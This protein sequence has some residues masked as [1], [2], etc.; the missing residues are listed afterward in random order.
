M[1]IC[2]IPETVR[3][4]KQSDYD[5]PIAVFISNQKDEFN[6]VPANTVYT[7]RLISERDKNFIGIFHCRMSKKEIITFLREGSDI[8]FK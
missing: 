6:V 4:I 7:Q 8:Q 2:N 3:R 1:S 5:R